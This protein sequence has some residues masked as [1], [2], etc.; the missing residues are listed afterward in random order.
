M[1]LA[2]RDK[3]IRLVLV[4]SLLTGLFALLPYYLTIELGL[5]RYYVA[6]LMWTPALG[7]FATCKIYK[8]RISDLGWK[9]PSLSF[10][11]W[12]YVLPAIYGIIAYGIIWIS[13]FGGLFDHGFIKE[14]GSLFALYGW[15]KSSTLIFGII[16]LSTVGMLWNLITSLGEEIGWRGFLTPVLMERFSFPATSIITGLLWS[17]WHIPLILYTNYN[18]GP[19]DLHIQLINFTLGY[20]G[21]SFIMTYLRVRSAS[22]WPA[23]VLH[24]AHNTFI[25][26]I[27]QPMTVKYEGTAFYAGEFG[28]VMP[29][30]LLILAGF[31]WYR[32]NQ[33]S[34]SV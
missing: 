15:S 25:L 34:Q 23:T 8:I 27:L 2:S 12:A 3:T 10:N 28:I 18:A 19:Y 20:I 7:A 32:Y 9:W 5:R 30:V 21:L 31:V 11:L 14:L 16:M 26:Y 29:M 4:F 33:K 24:A 17:L 13:G 1:A 22:V 6:L